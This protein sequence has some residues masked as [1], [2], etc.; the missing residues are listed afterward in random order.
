[1][2]TPYLYAREKKGGHKD[3]MSFLAILFMIIAGF[4]GMVELWLRLKK[5]YQWFRSKLGKKK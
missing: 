3:M 1:M 5:C 2:L 4:N